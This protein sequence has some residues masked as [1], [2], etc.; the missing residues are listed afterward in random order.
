MSLRRSRE[1][2]FTFLYCEIN[3][4]FRWHSIIV[5]EPRTYDQQG[6]A[7]ASMT[8]HR[9]LSLILDQRHIKNVHYSHHML[10][11]SGRHIFPTLVEE[12]DSLIKKSFRIITKSNHR[13]KPISTIRML[14][15]T[16]I[17][18]PG[19]CKF[20]IVFIFSFLNFSYKLYCLIR[21]SLGLCIAS[22]L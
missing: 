17:T 16:L 21:R 22:I 1:H 19:S 8:M 7:S 20:K 3:R 4:C 18:Y 6:S 2:S 13:K 12:A 14:S 15:Y 9:N 11:S 10:K 5:D